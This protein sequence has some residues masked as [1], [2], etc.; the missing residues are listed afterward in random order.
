MTRD[1]NKLDGLRI[2][3]YEVDGNDNA[4][5][6]SV[7]AMAASLLADDWQPVMRVLEDDEQVHSLI[8]ESQDTIHCLILLASDDHEA[9]IVNLIGDLSPELLGTSLTAMDIDLPAVDC[10]IDR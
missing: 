2:R 6:A 8:N 3:V 4:V 7:Q 9:V 5:A 10:A 1:D